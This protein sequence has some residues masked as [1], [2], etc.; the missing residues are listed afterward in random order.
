[1]TPEE[2]R[3]RLKEEYKDHYR[4]V[5]DLKKK[6]REVKQEK[7]LRDTLRDIADPANLM[8]NFDQ[9][10][11][12]V[13]DK[14]AMAEERLSA[15]LGFDDEVSELD[16]DM[17]ERRRMREDRIAREQFEAE[18]KRKNARSTLD[19]IRMEMGIAQEEIEEK[20][21]SAAASR[22][23]IG[24]TRKTSVD[25]DAQDKEPREAKKTIGRRK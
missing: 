25:S 15:A 20:A 5:R 13:K 14:I 22:K 7:S 11:D 19:K 12:V 23:T 24:N 2:E 18:Q 4:K 10:L 1:M 9:A 3:E 16:Y 8:D 21:G 6:Y 17:E